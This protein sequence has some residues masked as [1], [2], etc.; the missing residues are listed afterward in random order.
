MGSRTDTVPYV[1]QTVNLPARRPSWR[2]G[3]STVAGP[4]EGMRASTLY[5]LYSYSR[6]MTW[7]GEPHDVQKRPEMHVYRKR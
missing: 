6:A 1:R 7:L 2:L 4:E 5:T 3:G